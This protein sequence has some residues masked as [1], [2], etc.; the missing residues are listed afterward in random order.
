[1]TK[2]FKPGD[3]V[4]YIKNGEIRY[5]RIHRIVFTTEG[6]GAVF[7]EG[8]S[9]KQYIVPIESLFET[10]EEVKAQFDKK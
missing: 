1:M 5:N 7:D 8:C 6:L 2:N 3:K 9:C 10:A 4:F